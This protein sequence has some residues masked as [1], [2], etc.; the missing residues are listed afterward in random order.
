MFLPG[1]YYDRMDIYR[2][3]VV[4]EGYVDKKKRISVAKNVP[5]RLYRISQRQIHTTN[6]SSF[7]NPLDKVACNN[8]VDL[9]AGDL[10]YITRNG[11]RTPVGERLKFFA[12]DVNRYYEPIAGSAQGIPHMETFLTGKKIVSETDEEME[13]IEDESP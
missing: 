10:V 2:T 9:R 13:I 8:N 3:E 7:T 11:G 12:G 6:T 1:W 5:C 4:T